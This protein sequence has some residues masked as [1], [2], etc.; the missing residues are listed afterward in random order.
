[1]EKPG[2][3]DRTSFWQWVYSEGVPHIRLSARRIVFDPPQLNDW[4][5]R[6]SSTGTANLL[7]GDGV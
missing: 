6:R 7:L 4:L 3:K 5:A 1:M 2:Y